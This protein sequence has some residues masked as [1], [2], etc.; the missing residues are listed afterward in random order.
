MGELV[1]DIQGFADDRGLNREEDFGLKLI[2]D[3]SFGGREILCAPLDN[4]RAMGGLVDR[5]KVKERLKTLQ[6]SIP[7]FLRSSNF[8]LV[9]SIVSPIRMVS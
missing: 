5:E 2:H 6:V 9:V 8:P 4:F 1:G 3:N 7:L